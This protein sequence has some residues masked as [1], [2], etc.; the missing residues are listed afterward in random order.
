MDIS[1]SLKKGLSWDTIQLKSKQESPDEIGRGMLH[2]VFWFRIYFSTT[3]LLIFP[4]VL[5]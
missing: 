3:S 1:L 4:S 5:I 2:F